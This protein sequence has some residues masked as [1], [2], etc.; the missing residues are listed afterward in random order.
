MEIWK[1]Q[2]CEVLLSVSAVTLTPEA[3]WTNEEQQAIT[4]GYHNSTPYFLLKWRICTLVV[5]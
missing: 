4:W 1:M 3:F 5:K 2:L